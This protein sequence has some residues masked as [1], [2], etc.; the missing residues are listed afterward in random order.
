MP[1]PRLI[2]LRLTQ[3]QS[4]LELCPP[5]A[6]AD[7]GAKVLPLRRNVIFGWCAVAV[8]I[9]VLATL[10]ASSFI[11]R[12]DA[13]APSASPVA[14]LIFAE[15]CTWKNA[16]QMDLGEGQRLEPGTL[17][18]KKGTAIIRFD[19]GAEVALSG[20]TELR[21]DSP[22]AGTLLN[23]EVVVRA[24]DGA[25]G[26]V[27]HTPE[28]N[29]VDL[30]TEFGVSVNQ[31]GETK[32]HVLEGQVAVR[33]PATRDGRGQIVRAGKAVRVQRSAVKAAAFASP[34]FDAI[35]QRAEPR[36]RRDLMRVYE[37]FFYEPGLYEPSDLAKGK[38]WSQPWRLR[39]AEETGQYE[40]STTTMHVVERPLNQQWR[41]KGGRRTALEMPPVSGIRLRPLANTLDLTRKQITYIS[42]MVT[43]P[44]RADV[45]PRLSGEPWEAMRLTLRSKQN[46]YGELLAFG[47]GWDGRPFVGAG[48]GRNYKG[49]RRFAGGQTLF[50]VGKI[51]SQPNA[52]DEV[53][54]R[55]YGQTEELPFAEPHAWDVTTRDLRHSG[56][57]NLLLLTSVGGSSRYFDELR[58]GP[59]WRSVVPIHTEASN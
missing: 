1:T 32:L 10:L 13:T 57:L 25:E 53:S 16:M 38:G 8:V 11:T 20:E 22:G 21:I 23:G 7:S 43:E 14:T 27:L 5:E 49:T 3:M 19:G 46:Y 55:V 18:L 45:S 29:L 26:F 52:P 51:A 9:A 56:K 28:T 6:V 50:C 4:L 42:F 36:E 31:N 44:E 41:V 2:Y 54:F 59:T 33:D 24:E 37:G 17:H 30:G 48:L 35:V 47:W 58:I 12:S 15:D 34:G 39:Q 40:D